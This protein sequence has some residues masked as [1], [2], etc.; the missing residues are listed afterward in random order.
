M[1]PNQQQPQWTDVSAS[2]GSMSGNMQS[3][4]M[5]GPSA[6]AHESALFQPYSTLD[7]PVMETIMR[8]VRAVY[9]KLKVVMLPLDK[10]VRYQSIA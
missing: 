1:Q 9:A 5:G 6:D 3:G 10:T 4:N 2:H 7:E 8:D